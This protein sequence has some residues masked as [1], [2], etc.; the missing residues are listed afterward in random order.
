MVTLP[1]GCNF[2]YGAAFHDVELA[3]DTGWLPREIGLEAGESKEEIGWVL[4]GSTQKG[5]PLLLLYSANESLT[6]S[7]LTVYPDTPER[8]E[9]FEAASGL[10]LDALPEYGGSDK[11]QRGAGPKGDKFIVKAPKAFAVVW[12]PNPKFMEAPAGEDK[13]TNAQKRKRDFVRWDG[14]K[15]PQAADVGDQDGLATQGQVQMIDDLY[16]EL[17]GLG[18]TV[19][20]EAILSWLQ[21]DDW[22]KLDQAGVKKAEDYLRE[23]IAALKAKKGA[24]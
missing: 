15:V 22:Y 23:K 20:A 24:A 21:V 11:P 5:D 19:K 14:E 1:V 6:W 8:R 9:A 16:R 7:F 10:R 3:I 17:V 2:D 12:K 18:A 13:R 4:R